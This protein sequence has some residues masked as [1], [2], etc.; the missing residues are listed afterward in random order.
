MLPQPNSL[1]SK[2]KGDIFFS[3][4]SGHPFQQFGRSVGVEYTA[5]AG[6]RQLQGCLLNSDF[7]LLDILHHFLN[8]VTGNQ[9]MTTHGDEIEDLRRPD[10]IF[11]SVN[12]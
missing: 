3:S 6:L 1:L 5:Q 11:I 10:L 4:K 9:P 7:F 12:S 8:K 2:K